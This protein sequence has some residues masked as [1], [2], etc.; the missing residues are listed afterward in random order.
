MPCTRQAVFSIARQHANAL[1]IMVL[2]TDQCNTFS[3]FPFAHV[4]MFFCCTLTAFQERGVGDWD[5]GLGR[6]LLAAK[7][8]V[9][10]L[11]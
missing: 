1:C 4:P 6:I 7:E 9:W 11:C 5:V 8:K 2:L 10:S 3:T